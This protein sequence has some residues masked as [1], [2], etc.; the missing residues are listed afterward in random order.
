M[1]S[2]AQVLVLPQAR[3]GFVLTV[4]IS[5][6]FQPKPPQTRLPFSTLSATL[7]SSNPRPLQAILLLSL[8]G[9]WWTTWLD[10]SFFVCRNVWDVGCSSDLTDIN[11]PIW[12]L[13]SLLPVS[14]SSSAWQIGYALYSLLNFDCWIQHC[15][16]P[17]LQIFHVPWH[18]SKVHSSRSFSD[19]TDVG[20]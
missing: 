1:L 9:K 10:F 20:W 7:H 15:S 13:P 12:L 11:S 17:Y 18:I 19:N 6:L 4:N 14:S 5:S 16:L 8:A 2:T 3:T